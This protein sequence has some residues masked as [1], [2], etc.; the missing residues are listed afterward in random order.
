MEHIATIKTTSRLRDE[1][2][3]LSDSTPKGDECRHHSSKFLCAF[4]CKWY[5]LFT[6]TPSKPIMIPSK[7]TL[8]EKK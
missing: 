4:C 1:K 7:E 8:T 5:D 6:D 2:V 3:I